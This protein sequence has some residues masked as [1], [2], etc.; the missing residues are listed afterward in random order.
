MELNDFNKNVLG[1]QATVWLR[2]FTCIHIIYLPEY[3][4][5]CNI[6]IY[7]YI[8]I[9]TYLYVTYTYVH[10]FVHDTS[11]EHFIDAVIM[12]YQIKK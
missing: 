1:G 7:M 5:I 2:I 3:I 4:Y 11:Y 10:M 12:E 6:H 8:I 9:C